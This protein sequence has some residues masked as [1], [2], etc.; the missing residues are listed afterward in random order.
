MISATLTPTR[1]H[2][3]PQ[4]DPS[5]SESA[6]DCAATTIRDEWAGDASHSAPDPHHAHACSVPPPLIQGRT[7]APIPSAHVPAPT[8]D[9]PS[10]AASALPHPTFFNPPPHR[11]PEILDHLDNPAASLQHVATANDTTVEALSAWLLT[12]Q[13]QERNHLIDT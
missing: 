6:S 8:S 9:T 1:Q 7:P 3:T 2:N 10:G 5:D 4:S 11:I 12:P 13:I